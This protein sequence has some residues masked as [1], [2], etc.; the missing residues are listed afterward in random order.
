[1]ANRHMKRGL[2]SLIFKETETKI[3]MRY[4]FHRKNG[5]YQREKNQQVDEGHMRPGND[6]RISQ[7]L[8][9][10]SEKPELQHLRFVHF[11]SMF[12]TTVLQNLLIILA[13]ISDS[14]LHTPM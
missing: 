7:F 2:T 9:Q 1:M 13:T 5:Y 10:L 4:T 11:L 8:Q 3:A 6:T 14:H 12:Q